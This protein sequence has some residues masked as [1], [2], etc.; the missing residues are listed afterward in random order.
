MSGMATVPPFDVTPISPLEPLGG[1]KLPLGG[2][3]NQH[4][5]SQ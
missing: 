3:G 4:L 5:I 2:A 1:L